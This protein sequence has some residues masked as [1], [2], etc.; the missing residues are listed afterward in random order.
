MWRGTG[1]PVRFLILDAR[2]CLPILLAVLH[3]SWTTL[4]VGVVGTVFFGTI[5]FFGLTL[6]AALRTGRRWLV[7]RRRTARPTWNR[8]RYS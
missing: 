2:S 1:L 8:R 7:G 3:W 6:P 4:I 5:S